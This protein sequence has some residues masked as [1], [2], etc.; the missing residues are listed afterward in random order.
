MVSSAWLLNQ[1][2]KIIPENVIFAQKSVWGSLLICL[3]YVY[4]WFGLVFGWFGFFPL[5]R[6][7]GFFL[8][9]CLLL[10]GWLFFLKERSKHRNVQEFL[11]SYKKI[12]ACHDCFRNVACIRV[13]S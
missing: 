6:L 7:L 3:V 13:T 10:V 11:N 5:V 2:K 8:C 9:C 1:L 12:G 4:F